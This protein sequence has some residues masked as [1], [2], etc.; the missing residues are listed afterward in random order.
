MSAASIH[1][2]VILRWLAERPMETTALRQRVVDELGADARFHTCD[3]TDLSFDALVVL[4][5]E[6]GKIV[7]TAEGWRSDLA[8]VCSGD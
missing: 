4:L 7:P 3:M 5:A 6:R 1:G 2:H 8:Q